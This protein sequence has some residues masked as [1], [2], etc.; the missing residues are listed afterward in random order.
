MKE[1]WESERYY[2]TYTNK[3]MEK[4]IDITFD[5]DTTYEQLRNYVN[6][7]KEQGNVIAYCGVK[8]GNIYRY[9][10]HFE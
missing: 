7:L 8:T 9:A 6:Q 1:I 2:L 3:N 10:I 4:Y 5:K